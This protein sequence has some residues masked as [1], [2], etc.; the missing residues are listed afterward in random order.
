MLMQRVGSV[1]EISRLTLGGGGLG[2]VWGK[3]DRDEAVAT[4]HAAVAGGITLFDLAPGY[5]RGEAEAVIGAAFGGAP[6]AGA[7]FTTKCQLGTPA[8][9]AVAP[10]I[11]RSLERSLDTMGL[12]RVD[13]LF[14]H[15]NII[16]DAYQYP[17]D[18]AAQHRFATT[19][20]IY[21]EQVIPTFEAL[22][23][24]GLIG[25][26]GIT[27]VGL[28]RVII[29]A[30][31]TDPRPAVVQCVANCLDSP[32]DMRRYNEPAQPRAIIAA[33]QAAGVG[34][35][36][37]RAVQ[38][39]ALTDA[40]DRELNPDGQDFKDFERAAPL[41]Q[42]ARSL[43]TPMA[44]LAHRYALGMAGVASV[45]LGV[46]NRTELDECLAAEASGPLPADV[47]ARIDAIAAGI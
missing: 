20:S 45:V 32:G 18:S 12:K 11:R 26:W 29:A 36:G 17:H 9:D 13:I 25:H 38:A 31:Q 40:L 8:A 35:L 1:G 41:R 28:P 42:L 30:L 4:V 22:R 19:E 14:L 21:R 37:I 24:E 16:P 27:G 3:T 33:A 15:S 7:R 10:T 6:P 39:G 2:Q 44:V 5:G 34:V 47:V 23:A 46:K 43:D